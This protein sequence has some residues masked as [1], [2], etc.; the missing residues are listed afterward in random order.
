MNTEVLFNSLSE[1]GVDFYTGVPDSQLKNACNY[2]ENNYS[3]LGKNWIVPNEGTAVAAA[4]GYYLATGRIPCV[5]MQNS[6]IGNAVNPICS[7][8]SPDVYAVPMVFLIG[9]RGEP[10]V[11]DEPQHVFQG[12]ITDSMMD[13]L[14]IPY[15]IVD[16]EM[17]DDDFAEQFSE[18]AKH[19]QSGKSIAILLKKGS[20]SKVAEAVHEN[21][22]S[23]VRESAIEEIL[24]SVN[25]GIFV[26]S[27]GKISREVF[28]IRE[29]NGQGHEKDFLTVGSMGHCS[30]IALAIA[31]E[32]PERNVVCIDGDGALLMHMGAM[33]MAGSE[34]PKHFIHILLDNGAHETVGGSP[35]ISQDIDFCAV[36]K[37]CGYVSVIDINDLEQIKP[38]VSDCLKQN[39]AC[40]IRIR[41]ALGSREDLGRPT[42]TPLQNKEDFMEYLRK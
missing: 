2:M 37:A 14:D 28:E 33:A 40:F 35:T 4:T 38:A 16:K 32:K 5:Y 30:T 39:G 18:M 1:I 15:I 23:V 22:Y 25:N 10:G 34:E 42:N 27:T 41:V 7:L 11:K 19:L 13:V 20:L 17:S 12:K 36:A 8:T 31:M 9:W 3:P 29:K 26:S 21:P 6:G 24:Q